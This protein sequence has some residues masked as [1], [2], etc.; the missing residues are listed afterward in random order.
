[1]FDRTNFV[2]QSAAQRVRWRADIGGAV[3]LPQHRRQTLGQFSGNTVEQK[4]FGAGRAGA[5]LSR[6]QQGS[7]E[8]GRAQRHLLAS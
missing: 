8:Y 7:I 5:P 3:E 4:C 2:S 6:T 1:V